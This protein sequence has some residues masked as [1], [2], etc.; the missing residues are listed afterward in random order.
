M[1]EQ[2][3]TSSI[4]RMESIESEFNISLEGLLAILHGPDDE[5]QFKV[6]LFYELTSTGDALPSNVAL[7]FVAYSEEGQVVGLGNAYV[8]KADFL[9]IEPKWQMVDCKRRPTRF[10]LY[11]RAM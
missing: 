11:P 1:Q 9:G 4:Q 7:T 10:R 3:I 8:L 2:E 5:D 6:E